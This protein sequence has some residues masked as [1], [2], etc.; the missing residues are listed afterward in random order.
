[1]G[2]LI[3]IPG[4]ETWWGSRWAFGRILDRA[5]KTL[6]DPDDIYA[7]D[8]GDGQQALFLDR[9]LPDQATRLARSLAPAAR[10]VARDLRDNAKAERHL[11]EAETLEDLE[12]RLVATY[13][14]G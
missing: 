13:G 1:M 2:M 3:E 10:D 14:E 5:R 11:V 4:Y 12:R 7:L 9:M 8:Q 6:T